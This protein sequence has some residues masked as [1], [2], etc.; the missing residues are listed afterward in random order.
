MKE[1]LKSY[2]HKNYN[3]WTFQMKAK[4]LV[5][6]IELIYETR[7]FHTYLSRSVREVNIMV[8]EKVELKNKVKKAKVDILFIEN[9]IQ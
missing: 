1:L 5:L 7:E 2:T 8:S 6:L 4:M 3:K 9:K